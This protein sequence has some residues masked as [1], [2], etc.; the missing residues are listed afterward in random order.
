MSTLAERLQTAMD[1]AV[2]NRYRLGKDSGVDLGAITRILQGK[3]SRLE[4]GTLAALAKRCGVRMEWLSTGEGSM[5]E[6][7]GMRLLRERPEWPE[8]VA[9]VRQLHPDL[10]DVDLAAVGEMY[11]SPGI[12]PA[13]LDVPAVAALAAMHRDW[14]RRTAAR[15]R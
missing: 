10:T 1:R 12:F 2:V 14:A 9:A 5:L 6:T 11:D 3:A 8:L 13:A 7:G 15:A 4:H